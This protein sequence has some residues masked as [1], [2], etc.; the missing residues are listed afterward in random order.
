MMAL[1]QEFQVESKSDSEFRDVT[2][3]KCLLLQK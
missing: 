1:F 3:R 2:N